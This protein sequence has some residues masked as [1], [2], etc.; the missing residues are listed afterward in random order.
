[1]P[2]E[3]EETNAFTE[4]CNALDEW[5]IEYAAAESRGE[6][7]SIG[8]AQWRVLLAKFVLDRLGVPA[9]PETVQLVEEAL[10]WAQGLHVKG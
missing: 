7:D 1:M 5:E 3:P 9:S 10:W 4:M 6:R 2:D 8:G